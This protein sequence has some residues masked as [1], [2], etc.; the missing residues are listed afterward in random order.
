MDKLGIDKSILYAGVFMAPAISVIFTMNSI[1]ASPVKV[2]ELM[3]TANLSPLP[4]IEWRLDIE[5]KELECMRLVVHHEARG[6]T[7]KGQ[8]AVVH[9]V[10]N[11]LKSARYPNTICKVIWQPHQ[12]TDIKHYKSIKVTNI[13]SYILNWIKGHDITK[14][15]TMYYNPDKAS[16]KWDFT[17]IAN[18]VTIGNHKFFKE[19]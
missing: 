11:R 18:T 13:D 4:A 7:N 6:E 2:K 14:G 8:E 15:A 16:P 12:F 5:P 3:D 19:L 9:T 17:K 1:Q 10:L